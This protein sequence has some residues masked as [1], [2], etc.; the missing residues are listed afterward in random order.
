[1][2][3]FLS[4]NLF[5]ILD[6]DF[7]HYNKYLDLPLYHN[8]PFDRMI[9]AQAEKFATITQDE[10]FRNYDVSVVWN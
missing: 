3:H 9:I 8:D 10:K 2:S 4:H 1:M 7:E 5:S 6:F